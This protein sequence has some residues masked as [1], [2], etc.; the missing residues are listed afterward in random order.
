MRYQTFLPAVLAVLFSIDVTAAQHEGQELGEVDFPISCSEPAQEE[1]HAGLAQLHHMM[2]GQ[3]REH[4]EAAAEA[5]PEC[6]M[7]H[8]GIAMAS[9]QPLWHPTSEEDIER[10]R[11]AV[12]AARET[13]APTPRER[14]HIA[15]VEAFFTEPV[16]PAPSRPADH[17]ARVSAWKEAQRELH[18]AHR[19]DVD[20]AAFYALAKVA[21]AQARFSPEEEPD[22]GRQRQAGTL[23]LGYLERHPEHPGLHHY[24][25]H[26][27]DSAELAPGAEEVAEAYD[28]LAPET[29]HALHMPSH[30]FVR[31][32]RWEETAEF[33]E[34]SARAALR[35][36]ERNPA[37]RGYAAM[38][39]AHALDYMMYAYLQMGDDARARQ[40][41]ERVRGVDHGVTNLGFAYGIAAPQAR[42]YLEQQRWEE[43]ARLEPRMPDVI[44]WAD[45]P[46]ADALFHYARGLGAARSGDLEQAAAERDRIQ[47]AVRSL[48]DAGDEYW[49]H[50]TE[51]LG[52][53]VDAWIVY[54]RGEPERALALMSEAAD[55]EDSMEKHPI[56]P[57]EVLPVRELLG[58]ML[59]AQGR[60]QEAIA[61]YEASLERTPNRRYAL[62][63][64]EWAR[65]GR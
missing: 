36:A 26:A 18:E 47:A 56:T 10:G 24:L 29:V 62:N 13:G 65:T 25:L 11:A 23:L 30:I 22:F 60:T 44:D 16:P 59:L 45:V 28:D 17:E 64:L 14:A 2:Y 21:Y 4:F 19:D 12:E 3:A 20:A 39:H 40:T 55:H 61:A 34:R 57:G 50:M 48:R 46:A 53:A 31:L 37:E 15:A 1:F 54:E 42:Y 41:L 9:F 51:A 8:W 49:A 7:A 5:D 33:N 38:H 6:A 52:R 43:A 32:G 63:G 27:Y 35:L 58:D